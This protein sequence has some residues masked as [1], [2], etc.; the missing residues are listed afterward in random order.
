M[1]ILELQLFITYLR[2]MGFFDAMPS[3]VFIPG[4]HASLV[5]TMKEK[6]VDQSS[7]L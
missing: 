6:Q 7:S 2:G 3:S 5:P 1:F 4:T